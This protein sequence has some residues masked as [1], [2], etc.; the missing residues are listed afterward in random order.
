MV[1]RV[2]ASLIASTSAASVLRRF[3]NH[4]VFIMRRHD[5]RIFAIFGSA[6]FALFVPNLCGSTNRGVAN[7]K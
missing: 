1:L 3:T 2:T 5:S 6:C 4:E 7:V